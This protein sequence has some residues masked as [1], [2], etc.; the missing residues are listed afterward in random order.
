[1]STT[2]TYKGSTLTTVNNQTRTLETAGTYLEDDITLVDVSQSSP[3]LQ[4]K[5]VSPSTSS[6]TVQPDVGYD[7]LSSVTV[8]AMPSGS[9]TAPASIT[10]NSPT[11]SI[12]NG[13]LSLSQVISVT[14]DVSA[15]YINSG[16]A[17]NSTV[18]LTTP[19]ATE[20]DVR[21]NT[22]VTISGNTATIDPYILAPAD[23]DV[24][25]R[26][27]LYY[28]GQST[29]VS[30]SQLV[31]GTLSITDNGVYD[32]TNYYQA[33]VQVDSGGGVQTAL[34][35]DVYSSYVLYYTDQNMYILHHY[36]N[37]GRNSLRNLRNQNIN[38]YDINILN[39]YL[40]VD[41]Q[42]YNHH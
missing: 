18:S 10:G 40:V 30:A 28:Y 27:N 3:T 31:S 1:M 19:I 21:P 41:F 25:F 23:R 29:T 20:H 13:S 39:K 16:T 4:S 7:G 24:I 33:S 34:V 9:A 32:V 38:R 17:G 15:G 22:S 12:T 5:T 2:V 42:F 8:N 35:S 37:M 14:P 26:R 6:Q 11:V 36:A